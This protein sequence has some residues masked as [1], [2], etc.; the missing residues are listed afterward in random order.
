[1]KVP[2]RPVWATIY[3]DDPNKPDWH[4]QELISVTRE[5][6]R[7]ALSALRK[8]NAKDYYHN[9]GAAQDKIAAV[10]EDDRS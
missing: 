2:E 3:R 7:L 1:M 10:L 8:Q 6:L 5:T 4:D 9:Y